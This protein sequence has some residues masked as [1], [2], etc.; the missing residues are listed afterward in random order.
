MKQDGGVPVKNAT[1]SFATAFNAPRASTCGVLNRDG[2][3]YAFLKM[4]GEEKPFEVALHGVNS[5]SEAQRF[6]ETL[7][8]LRHADCGCPAASPSDAQEHR[9]SKTTFLRWSFW[10]ALVLFLGWDFVASPDID[11]RNEPPLIAAGSGQVVSGGH[12]SAPPK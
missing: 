7:L 9:M 5:E 4:Q 2:I 11:L 3:F 6:F 1:E 12:C 8:L 10:A